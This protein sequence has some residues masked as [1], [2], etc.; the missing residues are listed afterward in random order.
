MQ[1]KYEEIL[2][3]IRQYDRV[4]VCLSGGA[5]SSLVAIAAVDA[6][7]ASNVIAI[8]ADTEFFTGEE[9]EI[10][11]E[12]CKRLGIRHLAPKT[13]PITIKKLRWIR[14]AEN[15]LRSLGYEMVRVRVQEKNARIEVARE[16][17]PM[18]LENK[19]EV[20]EELKAIGFHDVEIDEQGYKRVQAL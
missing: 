14:A 3:I 7:G 17:V 1:E 15:Y 19:E 4:G 12:L 5:D 13:E 18:L 10:S 6:L 20:L 11:S 16:Q 9:M 8:T 2:N